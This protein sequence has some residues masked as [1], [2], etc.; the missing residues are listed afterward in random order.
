[1]RC[2]DGPDGCGGEVSE[3]LTLF[4]SGMRFPRCEIHYAAYCAR[5]QPKMD[6]IARRYP[7]QAPADFDPTY[8][9]ERWEED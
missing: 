5:L 8:A 2:L 9:G 6:D 7:A 4:G 3:Y 1:M